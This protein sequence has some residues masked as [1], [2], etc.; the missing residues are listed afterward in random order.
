MQSILKRLRAGQQLQLDIAGLSGSSS[1]LF[2]ARAVQELER[3]VCCIVPA[4]DQLETI[5]RDTALFTSVPILIYPSFEIPPYTALSPD[6]AT[7]GT[8]LSTLYLLQENTTPCIVFTS[9]EA[10]LRRVIPRQILGNHCEL[11][12]SREETDREQLISSLTEAGYEACDMVRQ[13]G[14]MAVRGGIIDIF[15]PPTSGEPAPLRLDF[16]GD[17]IESIR[18]FDPV[19]Q[20]SKDKLEEAILLPATDLLFPA[21]AEQEKWLKFLEMEIKKTSWP[22]EEQSRI[23]NQLRE[24]IPFAGCEFFLPLIYN[25]RHK[26]Q[27]LLDYL[28]VDTLMVTLD[29]ISC[30]QQT[31]LI[32]ERITANYTE[33]TATGKAVLPPAQL[34]LSLEEL[35]TFT[36]K[37]S[38]VA[39]CH[40]PDPDSPAEL[41]QFGGGDHS[42]LA[43]EIE[44]ERKKRGLLAPLADRIIDWSK[45]GATTIIACK[46]SRQMAHMEEMLAGY[47]IAPHR[48]ASP[49]NRE[50][51]GKGMVYLTRHLLSRGFD[52]PSEQLHFLSTAELFGEKRLQISR[53]KKR[54]QQGEPVQLETLNPGDIIVHRDHGLGTF[55]GLINMELAGRRS[56]F[57]LIEFRGG[58]KLYVPVDRLHWVSRYQGI[59]DQQPRLDRLGSSKWQATKK[60]VTDAVWKVAQELLA[61]YARRELR[62][63][64]SSHNLEN[65]LNSW[66]S[67]L[68]MKRLQARPKPLMMFSMTW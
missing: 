47:K 15:P 68:S 58:D 25:N 6:P 55:C 33:A 21:G 49:I 67:L 18:V 10:V 54:K 41:L 24:H 42:L 53:E 32:S 30:R 46:S 20:R 64:T 34:F 39:L 12:I 43:Q 56:D 11:V 50:K 3:T 52:L 23:I 2:L 40:L 4:E 48:L 31:E 60:K 5:A 57:M 63:D 19:S 61:I 45:S 62:K 8:R 13:V 59:S 51:L 44:L 14:D 35:H 7:T 22:L 26:I 28:P 9:A 29:P 37:T 36:Q 16:F 38:H 27:G 1:A 66:K 17:T 65:S